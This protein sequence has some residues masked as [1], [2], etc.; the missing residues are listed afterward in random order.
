M[1]SDHITRNV[2]DV[3]EWICT[4]LSV[5]CSPLLAQYAGGNKTKIKII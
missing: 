4:V 1:F 2:T 3:I 5:N